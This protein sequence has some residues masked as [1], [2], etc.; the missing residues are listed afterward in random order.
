MFLR[1][2][3]GAT[4][5]VQVCIEQQLKIDRLE[6]VRFQIAEQE[7]KTVVFLASAD[8]TSQNSR[9]LSKYSL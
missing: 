3:F 7:Q 4:P 8:S 5:N 2:Q 9:S 6:V 1:M